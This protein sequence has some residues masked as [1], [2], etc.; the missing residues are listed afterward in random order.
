[1]S[2]SPRLAHK[3]PVMQAT[4]N[5]AESAN[6]Q[7]IK[8]TPHSDWLTERARW[9]PLGISRVGPVRKSFLSGHIINSLL[10]KH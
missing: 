1:M 4:Y 5:M 10:T 2:R 8:R 6:G 9:A 3:A 7:E